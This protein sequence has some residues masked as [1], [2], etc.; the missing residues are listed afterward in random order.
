MHVF[1]VI[2]ILF[3]GD[4][5]HNSAFADDKIKDFDCISEIALNISA[6]QD[7]KMQ[8]YRMSN[9]PMKIS[10]AGDWSSM[11]ITYGSRKMIQRNFKCDDERIFPRVITCSGDLGG[12][13]SG[14]SVIFNTDNQRFSY[15]AT[16]IAGYVLSEKGGDPDLL[17]F[18][19]CED[20]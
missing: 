16:S 15:F 13:P 20:N 3:F 14:Q 18:G 7:G 12:I 1:F 19:S 11:K 10:L 5:L 6:D 9:D 8:P 2:P 17:Y 4:A